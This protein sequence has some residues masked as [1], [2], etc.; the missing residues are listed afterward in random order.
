MAA[1]LGGAGRLNA[2]VGVYRVADGTGDG[3]FRERSS[4]TLYEIINVDG[5]LHI[6]DGDAG[7]RTRLIPASPTV[8]VREHGGSTR[9]E[10]VRNYSGGVSG[11]MIGHDKSWTEMKK[12]L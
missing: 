2:F 6:Q 10:F 1:H 5:S 7:R 9:V 3:H 8:F 11:L 4:P 12:A